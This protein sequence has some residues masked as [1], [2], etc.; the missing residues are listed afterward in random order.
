VANTIREQ[1]RK[2][3][4][5]VLELAQNRD[6]FNVRIEAPSE[7]DERRYVT[8]Q[9]K[10]VGRRYARGCVARARATLS[11]GVGGVKEVPLHWADTPVVFRTAGESHVDIASGSAWRLDVAFSRRVGAAWLASESALFGNYYSD[12]ELVPGQHRV[13]ILV[14]CD[15]SNTAVSHLR[16]AVS[17]V[18]HE[19]NAAVEP[20]RRSISAVTGEAST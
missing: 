12:A 17:R 1:Y 13:E 11:P 8:V 15:D 3:R 14:T 2:P 19:L 6:I 9:V 4:L 5:Q 20:Q 10:N 16:L 18:W 7:P